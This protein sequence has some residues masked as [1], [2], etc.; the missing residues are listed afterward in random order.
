MMAQKIK[1]KL[2][3]DI[4]ATGDVIGTIELSYLDISKAVQMMEDFIRPAYHDINMPC[5]FRIESIYY[6]V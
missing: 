1:I 4:D 5:A 2:Y 6:D 3:N